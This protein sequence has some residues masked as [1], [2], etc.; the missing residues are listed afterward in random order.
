MA[1]IKA[2]CQQVAA[3]WQS[4]FEAIGVTCAELTGDTADIDISRIRNVDVIVTT[5]EKWISMIR[6]AR[7]MNSLI[8][9][10]KLFIIDE[11]E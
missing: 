1:P 11:G 5:P 6:S 3:H 9:Q 2:L 7:D 8:K 4:C 10:V